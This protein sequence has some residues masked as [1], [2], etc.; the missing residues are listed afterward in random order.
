MFVKIFQF[1][2]QFSDDVAFYFSVDR[3][4]NYARAMD[5]YGF[6]TAVIEQ[7]VGAL[8]VEV[9]LK[10][11]LS[12]FS[13]LQRLADDLQHLISMRKATMTLVIDMMVF[14][15]SVQY[16]MSTETRQSHS[17]LLERMDGILSFF[18]DC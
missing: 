17:R 18:V 7:M 2:Q 1:L 16:G 9:I 4:E 13:A 14:T 3:N 5:Y 15:W 11:V 10:N 8:Y 6:L 12:E